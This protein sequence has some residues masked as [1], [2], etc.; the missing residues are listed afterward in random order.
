[1]K[2][3]FIT[4][5]F[6][7]QLF[8]VQPDLL[9]CSLTRYDIVAASF[10]P[11]SYNVFVITV[12]NQFQ[13]HCLDKDRETINLIEQ[14]RT[15]DHWNGR[16]RREKAEKGQK[17]NDARE[18]EADDNWIP[19]RANIWNGPFH[20]LKQHLPANPWQ[21]LWMKPSRFDFNFESASSD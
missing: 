21:C 18:G 3:S 15:R 5:T 20:H 9:A 14:I 11:L 19:N 4:I 2:V 12:A 1:M 17:R 13:G 6:P 16:G 8:I 10:L 7:P